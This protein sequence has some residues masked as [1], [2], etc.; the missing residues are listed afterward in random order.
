MEKKSYMT[1]DVEVLSTE[2][3]N[4]LAGSPLID[5]EGGT[6]TLSDEVTD[7]PD[8]SPMK[9]GKKAGVIFPPSFRL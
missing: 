1:P 2:T 3:E 6:G 7:G 9:Y 4:L 8:M 5:L